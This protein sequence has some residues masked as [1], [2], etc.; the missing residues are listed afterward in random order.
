MDH[1][2]D[3]KSFPF[4]F[5]SKESFICQKIYQKRS[6]FMD[7][8]QNFFLLLIEEGEFIDL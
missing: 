1:S 3:P 4:W 2:F 6:N 8:L 5:G 7:K